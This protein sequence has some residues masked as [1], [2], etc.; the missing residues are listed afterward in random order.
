MPGAELGDVVRT[1]GLGPGPHRRTLPPAERL[2]ADDR[3]GDLA[4][5]I[6]VADLDAFEPVL[7]LVVLEG[8]DAAGEA[9]VGGVLQLDGVVEIPGPHQAE[10]GPETLGLVEP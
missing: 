9:I 4:V 7:D 3:S 6:G 1:A 5:D 8:V 10:H 2:P